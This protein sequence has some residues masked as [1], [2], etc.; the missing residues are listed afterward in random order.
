M[1]KWVVVEADLACGERKV[2]NIKS[3]A[4]GRVVGCDAGVATAGQER[5]LANKTAIFE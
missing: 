1:C 2:V 5:L 3:A 4:G